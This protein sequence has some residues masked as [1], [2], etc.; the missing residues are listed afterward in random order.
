VVAGPPGGAYRLRKIARRHRVAVVAA[1]AIVAT[2]VA[3]LLVSLGGRGVATARAEAA[4]VAEAEAARQRDVARGEEEKAREILGV[5]R[6]MLEAA[7]PYQ[8]P[9]PDY[10]VRQLVLD[11]EPGLRD[12]LEGRP[13][14]EAAIRNTIARTYWGLEQYDDME[15]NVRRARQLVD[16]GPTGDVAL[17]VETCTL[18]GLLEIGR[19]RIPEAAREFE[20]AVEVARGLGE[21]GRVGWRTP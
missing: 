1:V 12:R 16:A 4:T 15:R 21:A 13:E 3:G 14:V 5:L 7:S 11:F 10:T 19:Y 2:L 9:D 20:R 6:E 17:L 18:A 8:E